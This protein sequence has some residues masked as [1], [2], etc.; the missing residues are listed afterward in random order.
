MTLQRVCGA[1]Q[2]AILLLLSSLSSQL[3]ADA[4][5]AREVSEKVLMTPK[6]QV[7]P[8]VA[9]KHCTIVDSNGPLAGG[10]IT[11]YGCS[12]DELC[13]CENQAGYSCGG[14]CQP[15]IEARE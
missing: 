7:E 2:V 13:V 3:I 8:A 5:T 11:T 14:S 4:Q 6:K 12:E 9:V 1:L 10:E 15:L